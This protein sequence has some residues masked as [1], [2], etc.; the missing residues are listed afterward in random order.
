MMFFPLVPHSIAI[1]SRHFSRIATAVAVFTLVSHRLDWGSTGTFG[2]PF[3]SIRATRGIG[4]YR[5]MS[6]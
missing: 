6:L 5:G 2:F 1:V 4:D 3:Y